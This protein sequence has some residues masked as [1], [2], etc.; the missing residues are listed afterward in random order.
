MEKRIHAIYSNYIRAV[1]AHY[2]SL[3][4]GDILGSMLS[5]RGRYSGC[6]LHEPFLKELGQT[7]AELAEEGISA[8]LADAL[9]RFMLLTDHAGPEH[10]ASIP[11]ETAEGLALP[12]LSFLTGEQLGVLMESYRRKLRKGLGLP[13]QRN[14][15]KAMKTALRSK[16]EP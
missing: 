8:D 5:G 6:S 14:V 10:P 9:L 7:I 16:P 12:L 11:L 13:C 15:L 3:K 2:E 4:T 1:D